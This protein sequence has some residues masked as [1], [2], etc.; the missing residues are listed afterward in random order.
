MSDK[1]P[2]EPPVRQGTGVIAVARS[3]MAAAFGVQSRKNRE[4]DFQH[5][6]PWHFVIGGLVGTAVFILF[7]VM[8]V[9]LVLP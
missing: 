2:G 5:G 6:K 9:K 7:V 4:R 8:L 3:V 1:N